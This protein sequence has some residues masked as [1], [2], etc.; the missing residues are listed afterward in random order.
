MSF[1][2]STPVIDTPNLSYKGCIFSG[3]DLASSAFLYGK[4]DTAFK[5]PT[6]QRTCDALYVEYQPSENDRS[7]TMSGSVSTQDIGIER[8][9]TVRLGNWTYPLFLFRNFFGRGCC[10]V[11][12]VLT[13]P[14]IVRTY[15][16]PVDYPV[17][18]I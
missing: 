14:F 6:L 4:P 9:I 13:N 18:F 10:C 16:D 5:L 15:L 12:W 2:K 17:S 8:R 1:D 3:I 7:L 11:L